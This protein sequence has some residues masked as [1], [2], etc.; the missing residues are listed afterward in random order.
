MYHGLEEQP[1][2]SEMP[3]PDGRIAEVRNLNPGKNHWWPERFRCYANVYETA[4]EALLAGKSQE[5]AIAA[6]RRALLAGTDPLIAILVAIL[7]PAWLAREVKDLYEMLRERN[8][9]GSR[10][11]TEI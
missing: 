2:Y 9:L 6:M 3:L 8:L 5:E 7:R 1:A 10:P 11:M 4:R